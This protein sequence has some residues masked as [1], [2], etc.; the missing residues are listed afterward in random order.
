LI[1]IVKKDKK[2]RAMIDEVIA[3][4]IRSGGIAYAEERMTAYRDQ[5]LRRLYEFPETDI[6]RALED[7][8]KYT[9]DRKK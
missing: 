8:V 1:G 7:L 2:T 3:E 6:R 5:A 4:V 9:I